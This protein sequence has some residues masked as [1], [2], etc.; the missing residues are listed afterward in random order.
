MCREHQECWQGKGLKILKFNRM[1]ARQVRG[2]LTGHSLKAPPLRSANKTYLFVKGLLTKTETASCLCESEALVDWRFHHLGKQEQVLRPKLWLCSLWW[3][4][5]WWWVNISWVKPPC[6]Y[7][8]IP[9]C[10]ILYF[11]GGTA[12]LAD[13]RITGRTKIGNGRGARV[14]LGAL[15]THIRSFNLRTRHLVS[16]P[17][18]I[19][20]Q[21]LAIV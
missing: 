1:Q 14:A 5:W 21:E 11:V 7:G 6:H 10:K 16:H 18:N 9:L 17:K 8:E 2:P 19:N 13:W 12:L 15:P 4:W 20:V 3:W